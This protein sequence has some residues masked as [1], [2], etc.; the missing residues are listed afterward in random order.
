MGTNP[1]RK[2][3]HGHK[4]ADALIAILLPNN[5]GARFWQVHFHFTDGI[6]LSKRRI[7]RCLGRINNGR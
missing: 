6:Y 2:V 3:S 4:P 7:R 1:L 5:F